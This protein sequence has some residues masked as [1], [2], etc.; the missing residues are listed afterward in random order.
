MKKIL[1]G[2]LAT[3]MLGMCCTACKD[4]TPDASSSSSAGTT[5][6][7]SNGIEFA[8]NH[9]ELE[10]GQTLQLEVTTAKKNAFVMMFQKT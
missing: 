6:T 4:K 8:N 9:I 5:S 10:I 3:V 7:E 1:C 2:V